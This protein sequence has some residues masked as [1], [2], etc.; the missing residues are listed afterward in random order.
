MPTATA[1]ARRRARLRRPRRRCARGRARRGADGDHGSLGRGGS[2]AA[3]L[4]TRA[5]R[6]GVERR[7]P[8]RPAALP[9]QA[10]LRRRQLR[11]PPARDG[12]SPTSPTPLDPFFFVLP[13]TTTIIGPASRSAI[14]AD[15]AGRV[16][17]EAELAVVIGRGGREH[18]ARRGALDHV[19][20]YSIVNDISARGRHRR[21]DPLAPPFAFDWLGSKGVDGFCPMGPGRDAGL[22]GRRSAATFR[23]RCSVNGELK[24][25]GST[26]DMLNDVWRL[27]E[28]V[29]VL[30]DARARRRDRHRHARGRRRRPR[31]A[32]RR[33]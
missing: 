32:A 14:S 8:A 24:Q 6:R 11:R 17:W 12:R 22:A 4:G 30:R 10:D 23:I 26:R 5:R 21:S 3:R 25:D 18:R 33:R 31:R 1:R 16:D 28:A 20:G 7:R 29:F 9:A 15:P 2:R 27:I 19:A 13:P